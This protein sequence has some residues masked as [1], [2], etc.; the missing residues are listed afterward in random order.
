MPLV[1]CENQLANSAQAELRVDAVGVELGLS[2]MRKN[3][4]WGLRTKC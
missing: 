2:S 3:I 1:M 4:D